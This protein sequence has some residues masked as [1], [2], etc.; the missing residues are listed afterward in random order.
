MCFLNSVTHSVWFPPVLSLLTSPAL[1]KGPARARSSFSLLLFPSAKFVNANGHSFCFLFSASL[2]LSSPNWFQWG[3]LLPLLHDG[4]LPL[5]CNAKTNAVS[6]SERPILQLSRIWGCAVS[7]EKF[8]AAD[9]MICVLCQGLNLHSR[10]K[11]LTLN[12][13]IC[14]VE[15]CL[16]SV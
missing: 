5:L 16:V 10:Q 11:V 8:R 14:S 9:L 1:S 3:H 12:V 6:P 2:F 15:F 7:M 4:N 13:S